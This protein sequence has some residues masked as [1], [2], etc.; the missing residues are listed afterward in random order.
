M[1]CWCLVFGVAVGVAVGIGIVNSG[2]CNYVVIGGGG[3]FCYYFPYSFYISAHL[4]VCIH[5]YLLFSLGPGPGTK[6]FLCNIH[7]D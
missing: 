5:T 4:E 7:C 2:L 6:S 3:T 1:L